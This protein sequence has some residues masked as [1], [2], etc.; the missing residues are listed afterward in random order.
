MRVG[1]ELEDEAAEQPASWVVVDDTLEQHAAHE[2]EGIGGGAC[3]RQVAAAIALLEERMLGLEDLAP[4][5]GVQLDGEASLVDARLGH[6]EGIHEPH[7]RV[8]P[9]LQRPGA[10][11]DARAQPS[12]VRE[13]VGHEV[14][15]REPQ[16]PRHG[17]LL[18]LA[19]SRNA[20]AA[21]KVLSQRQ[22]PHRQ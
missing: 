15:T 20:P 18:R 9:Q 2:L 16:A 11:R 5:G 17:D 7:V 8:A 12:K 1:E 10:A 3:A 19:S 6:A 14:A 21:L 4:E 13:H 22:Q